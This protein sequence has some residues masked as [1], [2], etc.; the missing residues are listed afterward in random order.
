MSGPGKEEDCTS[1]CPQK[2]GPDSVSKEAL[3]NLAMDN[4][5]S[6]AE[7]VISG[8]LLSLKMPERKRPERGMA[9]GDGFS[10]SSTLMLPSHMLESLFL[11]IVPMV[12]SGR[13]FPVITFCPGSWK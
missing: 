7:E 5:L 12:F 13:T 10:S 3:G 6:T 4:C 9:P 11:A 1:R 8:S 2:Q